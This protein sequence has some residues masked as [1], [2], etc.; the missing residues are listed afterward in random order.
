MSGVELV[1][2]VIAAFFAFGIVA[3]VL[4]VIALSALRGHRARGGRRRRFGQDDPNQTLSVDWA[5]PAVPRQPSAPDWED[6]P[7]WTRPPGSGKSDDIPPP[8][9]G[10]R[11]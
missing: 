8:W 5:R 4:A 11:G 9:P 3:G 2:G 7:G 1:A 6:R 10:R